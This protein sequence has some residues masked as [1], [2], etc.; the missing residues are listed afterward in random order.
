MLQTRTRTD[1]LVSFL[2]VPFFFVEFLLKGLQRNLPACKN[3]NRTETKKSTRTAIHTFL[4]NSK[5]CFHD[6]KTQKS[7]KQN[8]T[9]LNRAKGSNHVLAFM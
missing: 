4:Q 7:N 6:Q 5:A 8:L 9:A 3:Y 1:S 2:G